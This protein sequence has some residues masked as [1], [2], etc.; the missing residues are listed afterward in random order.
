M[1]SGNPNI[2]TLPVEPFL[3]ELARSENPSSTLRWSYTPGLGIARRLLGRGEILVPEPLAGIAETLRGRQLQRTGTNGWLLSGRHAGQHFTAD[4]LQQRLKRYGIE[5]SRE[6]RHAALLEPAARLP[7][8]IFA[9]RIGIH[10][11]RAAAWGRMAGATY[12]DYI[13]LRL[14]D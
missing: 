6:G 2:R 1:H 8:P 7:A 3:V 11:A 9:E 12:A 14:A 10:Q 4:R 13:A 5:R